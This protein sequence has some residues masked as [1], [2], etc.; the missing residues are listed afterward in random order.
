MKAIHQT[1]EYKQLV[2]AIDDGLFPVACFGVNDALTLQMAIA[3]QF[4]H[5]R[6]VLITESDSEAKKFYEAL[7][8]WTEGCLYFPRQ[9]ILFY[10]VVAHSKQSEFDRIEAL[11]GLLTQEKSFVCTSIQALQ[12]KLISPEAFEAGI[13]KIHLGMVLERD[14]LVKTLLCLGYERV[15]QV[16]AKG[17]YTVRG[18]LVDVFSPQMEHPIRIEFFDN[19]V[20]SL[21]FFDIQEQVSFIKIE[22][23]ILIPAQEVFF[24]EKARAHIMTALEGELKQSKM[25]GRLKDTLDTILNSEGYF[26]NMSRFLP[27]DLG[28]KVTLLDYSPECL[29]L[30][31]NS[32]RCVE[33]INSQYQIYLEA[34]KSHLEAKETFRF[35]M[36]RLFNPKA[37]LSRLSEECLIICN[38]LKTRLLAFPLKQTIEYHVMDAPLYH[39]KL[40]DLAS[41]LRRYYGKSYGIFLFLSHAAS[42][43]GIKRLLAEEDLPFTLE[44]GLLS[45]IKGKTPIQIINRPFYRGYTSDSMKLMFLTEH[46]IFG[47]AL[48]RSKTQG[49]TG[50]N[51]LIKSFQELEPGD[52]VVH[53]KHGI[54]KYEGIIQLKVDGAVKDYMKI[55]YQG[56]DLLYIPIEQMEMVQKYIGQEVGHSKLSKLGT[57]EWKKTTS[58]VKK[59]IED[60]TEVLLSLYAK[61]ASLKGYAYSEDNAWQQQFEESFPYE[62][63]KDQLKSIEEIKGDMQ[64]D[65]PMDRLLCGDVGFGK[66]E[67]AIRGIFKAVMDSKQVAYLVPTTI[68]A[69]QQYNNFVSRFAN[70]PMRIEMLS[71]FKTKKEQEK[72]L[73]QLQQGLVDVVVGTHR[74]LSTD[75]KFK[76]LGLLVIDEEQRFGVKHKERIKE[77]K[78]NIDVLTL[79]ATPIPRT[80]HMSLIGIR[81][82]SIIEEPPED[83]FPIQTYV[84]EQDMP[85]VKEA[86][87]REVDRGG[88]VFFVH[89]RVEDIDAVAFQIKALLPDVRVEFAHGQ[90]NEVKLEKLMLSFLQHEFDVLVCTTII[91]T[92]MD[93]SNVNTIIINHADKLGLSQLYQLRGRVG[94]S[95]RIAY[96]YLTYQKDKILSEI[97][98][99]RLKA[100]KEFTELGSGFK[101]AMKDLEIR[102]AGSLLGGD[103]HGHIAQ[104]GYDLYCK[105]LENTV[106]HFKGQWV[107]EDIDASI[108]IQINAFVP[109]SYIQNGQQKIDVYKRISAISSLQDR[110]KVEEDLVDRFGD[111]PLSVS[112]LVLISYIR[113]VCKKLRIERV[114]ETEQG[115][116]CFTATGFKFQNAPFANFMNKYKRSI[117][118]NAGGKPYFEVRFVKISQKEERVQTLCKLLVELYEAQLTE[119]STRGEE[120]A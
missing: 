91:E 89:N 27:L 101:I 73:E 87:H 96:C 66:T 93:I 16:E 84:I 97:A 85:L 9:E 20:D 22:E 74:L 28:E 34:Y 98:E 31:L 1:S 81:D 83:R 114:I 92:G 36:D 43:E 110:T 3:L 35:S 23:S 19:E 2:K 100:I 8:D 75:V 54:G 107:E 48:K 39:S 63:T 77:M 117:V 116:R 65:L 58:K 88:Q 78:A 52:L 18:S 119:N 76:D 99:K 80:L 45:S 68:L 50:K 112:N 5:Q 51:R 32:N 13:Q 62:E 118:L 44:D 94:R 111:V 46:E 108:E 41:D 55:H 4:K 103:Q 106:K 102:G 12:C 56:D 24:L 47:A 15:D 95:N 40:D 71:R 72:V 57:A 105:M 29:T 42:L 90:M 37:I 26:D 109:E 86:I 67:V 6:V 70:F 21:R 60:M 7:K 11:Y 104:I 14:Q 115:F 10:D 59:S 33:A 120:N 17:Q 69:Q 53:E 38:V 30:L 79:T 82:M 25:E 113:S 49:S 61:R 64:R